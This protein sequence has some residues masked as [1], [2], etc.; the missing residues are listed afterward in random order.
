MSFLGPTPSVDEDDRPRAR[1][2]VSNRLTALA[3]RVAERKAGRLPL[4]RLVPMGKCWRAVWLCVAVLAVSL[5]LSLWNTTRAGTALVR[6]AD[7]FGAHPWPTKTRIEILSPEFP[8]RMSRGEPFEIKFA[9]RGL[10]VG[11]ATVRIRVAGGGESEEQFPLAMN[12]DPKISSAA[13]VTARFDSSR[14]SSNF[15]IRVTSNDAD[16]DWREV[17]VVP[18][19][20]LVPLDGR[21][22]PQFHATPPAYTNLP[23]VQLPDGAA[24][25]EVPTGTLLRF[26][27]AT[28]VK[29]SAATLAFAGDKSVVVN[30]AP[31]AFL[32]HTNPLAAIGSQGLAEALGADIPLTISGDGTRLS[33]DFVPPL[34]GSYALR[35]TDDTGLTGT[36]LI[37]I[38]LTADPVPVVTLARPVAGF[39][40]PVL[41]PTASVVVSTTAEDKLYGVRSSFL[42]YRVG[43]D[44]PIH[45]MPLAQVPNVSG[46]GRSPRL[47]WRPGVR[48]RAALGHRRSR[49][50]SSRCR[51]SFATTAPP[52]ARAICSS[53]AP[54][55]TTGTMSRRSR[56]RGGV[57]PRWR[58]GLPHRRP[59]RRG[60]RRNSLQC[61]R[62]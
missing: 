49:T 36:R 42:E 41:A 39:D 24:V 20:R 62:S 30:A 35:L 28:D 37:E 61:A 8:T 1:R 53:S 52:F 6:L 46:P 43:R 22:S 32:G 12:N 15:E 19:P 16:T 9:V 4:D 56:G 3:V 45:V 33:A 14:V 54:R 47:A 10:L 48:C 13:V 34:S 23:A 60:C 38:R 18:P 44:G 59:S 29:L 5:P 7:P 11:P 17:T 57:P 27:A 26:R 58:F 31:V 40:P 55:P 21:P 25:I 51:R 50:A 2:G